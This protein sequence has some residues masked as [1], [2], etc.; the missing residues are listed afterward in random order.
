AKEII[1]KA[2]LKEPEYLLMYAEHLSSADINWVKNIIAKAADKYPDVALRAAENY[3]AIDPAWAKEIITESAQK[4]PWAAFKYLTHYWYIEPDLAKSFLDKAVTKA[5]WDALLYMTDYCKKDPAWAKL[6]ITKAAEVDPLA[7]GYYKSDI[8]RYDKELA[9][10]IF[11]CKEQKT[12]DTAIILSKRKWDISRLSLLSQ[13]KKDRKYGIVLIDVQPGFFDFQQEESPGRNIYDF[14]KDE[15]GQIAGFIKQNTNNTPVFLVET[16][17]YGATLPQVI[18]PNSREISRTDQENTDGDKNYY[19]PKSDNGAFES[20][21]IWYYL[22][23]EGIT[24]IILMGLNQSVCVLRT[25]MSARERGFNI[26][27][28]PDLI[29]D[30]WSVKEE[31]YS[32][33]REEPVHPYYFNN[34]VVA[35][36][37]GSIQYMIDNQRFLY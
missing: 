37:A 3:W 9:E 35:K 13:P 5:P 12:Q 28:S 24:D 17:G 18:D 36:D 33:G 22:K 6:I 11:T 20:S 21:T 19:L 16:R 32:S 34:G 7:A 10:K 27:T 30:L 1:D 29:M 31:K 26:V 4:A 14:H 25:A 8:C 15:I 2:A 23:K